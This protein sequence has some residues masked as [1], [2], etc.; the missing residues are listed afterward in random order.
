MILLRLI[1]WP[2]TRRHLA[3]T[4]LTTAGIVLGVGVFLGMHTANQSVLF[5]LHQ[6]V[7][8]LA[9]ATQLQVTAGESGFEEEVLERVQA[10]PEVRVAVPVIEAVVDTG[11][12]GQGSIMILAVDMTGDRSLR[13]YTI[14]SGDESIVDDPL[15]FLAQPDSLIVTREFA[16]QNRL[17]SGSRIPMRTMEGPKEFVV[18]GI[19]AP[20]GLAKAFGGNLAIMD[21]YAAQTVF[22]RGRKFD[23]IDLAVSEGTTIDQCRAALQQMLGPGF[24]VETPGSRG[25]QFD[26]VLRVYS[27]TMSITSIFALFIGMFIIYNSFAIAV[28]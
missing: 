5:A 18:R 7:D 8:R 22:G 14:E 1:S 23:R 15:V 9:G 6:T 27:V 2:Y 4:I 19:M 21:V 11:L 16:E 12:P 3:R 20:G 25:Q 26:S 13:D 28:T 17:Q 24:Q 10:R